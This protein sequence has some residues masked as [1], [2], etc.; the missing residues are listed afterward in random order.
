MEAPWQDYNK[1]EAMKSLNGMRENFTYEFNT[2]N[3][4]AL[5]N[6]TNATALD[7]PTAAANAIFTPINSFWASPAVWGSW[8]YVLLIF[9]TVGTI[10]I[11]SQ[12]LARTSIVCLFLGLL[13]SAPGATGIIYIPLPALH[14]L[15]IVTGLGLA[16]VLYSTFVGD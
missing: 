7:D 1:T 5:D 16:G 2:S 14:T 4:H 3:Y 10:Y 12:N 6:M 9:I 13:A 8:F 11:K 15:Y